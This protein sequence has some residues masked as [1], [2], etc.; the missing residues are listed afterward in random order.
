M[1]TSEQGHQHGPGCG[2]VAV[3]H[4][5]HTD[6]LQ[7]GHLQHP[8]GDH[9]DDHVITVSD[10]NPDQH[11]EPAGGHDTTHQHGPGCGHE[12]VPHGNHSDYLVD[13]RLHHQAAGH[14]DDHGVLQTA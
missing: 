13:G 11:T 3:Q 2:H 8:H 1:S 4:E 10:A 5:G 14:C 12:L 7:D 6:Y 9:V